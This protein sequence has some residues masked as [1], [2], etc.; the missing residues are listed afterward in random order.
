MK[1]IFLGAVIQR[2]KNKLHKAVINMWKHNY[3]ISEK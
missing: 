3:T 2:Y 1:N